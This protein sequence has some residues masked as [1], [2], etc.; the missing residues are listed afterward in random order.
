MLR[1]SRGLLFVICLAWLC[2]GCGD[3]D[4]VGGETAADVVSDTGGTTGGPGEDDT[5]GD[6]G[7]DGEGPTGE[8][9]G[10]PGGETGGP[11]GP[12]ALEGE[13]EEPDT[14]CL[15][16]CGG[17]ECG[18]DGCGGSCGD[19]AVGA[20]CGTDGACEPTPGTCEAPLGVL[21]GT[22]EG[23]TVDAIDSA[24]CTWGETTYGEGTVDT[25]LRFTPTAGGTH[26]AR[27]AGPAGAVLHLLTGCE[28]DASCTA[29]PA[30]EVQFEATQGQAVLLAVDGGEAGPF[31][32]TV[33]S[34][35][36][37]CP[38]G[39]CG[40]S[41]CGAVCLCGP[42]QICAAAPGGGGT[43]VPSDIGD[44]CE[45]ALAGGTSFS[46]E[47][48]SPGFTD[49]YSC[50]QTGPSQDVTY[51]LNPTIPV[52]VLINI[53]GDGAPRA[54]VTA[55]C[56][57]EASCDDAATPGQPLG[58]FA[59]PSANNRIVVEFG[60]GSSY[61]LTVTECPVGSCAGA[62]PCALGQICE[63]EQCVNPGT[64]DSCAEA[65]ALVPGTIAHTTGG[66]SDSQSCAEHPGLSEAVFTLTAP[67]AGTWQ[68]LVTS[69]APAALYTLGV[70][71]QPETCGDYALVPAE[72]E[73][74]LEAGEVLTV[75]VEA[76]T[77][78]PGV[79][80]EIGVTNC[81]A[82]CSNAPCDTLVCGD[83][84]GCPD[85]QVCVTGDGATATCEVAG[86]LDA[87]ETAET[88]D[89]APWQGTVALA[90]QVDSVGCGQGA[91]LGTADAWFRF[92]PPTTG[93]FAL[94]ISGPGSPVV[95]LP[96]TCDA[97]GQACFAPPSDVQLVVGHVAEER[98]VAVDAMVEA[99][100]DVQLTVARVFGLAGG[101]GAPC[102]F[103]TDCPLADACIA[104]ICALQCSPDGSDAACEG[105]MTG[106]RG[107]SFGCAADACV[108]AGPGCQTF[109]V[110]GATDGA[111]VTCTS[112]ADCSATS[113]CA[114]FVG[115]PDGALVGLCAKSGS[116]SPAGQP[117]QSA[118]DCASNVCVAG[119]CANL[120]HAAADCQST[121]WCVL[122]A[123]AAGAA[124][125]CHPAPAGATLEPCQTNSDCGSGGLCDGFASPDGELTLRCIE[126]PAGKQP[127]GDPC[128]EDS[129]CA[130][131]RCLFS[132]F[133]ALQLPYCS[134][135]C[136][137][138]SDCTG[139]LTCK[140][141]T[142]WDM[143]TPDTADDVTLPLC[144]AGGQDANCWLDGAEI[145]DEPLGCTDFLSDGT[146]GLCK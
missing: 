139:S 77:G 142:I 100:D 65:I 53:E 9:D 118:K 72:I 96:K 92:V 71:G 10:D 27:V 66:L 43:C 82:E 37:P 86:P 93:V 95:L 138:G 89:A 57:D 15:P 32:L 34:C 105:A 88:I 74:H 73:R 20:Q 44:F 38:T 76:P 62:C 59:Y 106:P 132:G 13:V 80:F 133:M 67:Q 79:G 117:C 140:P 64:G 25:V 136:A 5:G 52:G 1:P 123:T 29:E 94:S 70:C 112:N 143:G 31:E 113:T 99:A 58:V 91:G 18:G 101:L 4:E 84:C 55:T 48:S 54:Y 98:F 26:E 49:V 2:P 111:S 83:Q 42:K 40:A 69:P 50:G 126:V 103:A 8:P 130:A 45:T 90:E 131:A 119:A 75:A 97:G 36:D 81:S 129:D 87:C 137:S 78:G 114:G 102:D 41:K 63:A 23:T 116:L 19:C 6:P 122:T 115:G 146:F 35:A 104:G 134:E 24:R 110:A 121:D 144:V 68:V 51:Q 46:D 3:D 141:V 145:C 28:A 30:T 128:S 47:K 7:G 109:C 127:T 14:G 60:G 33:E 17:R 120:C 22:H 135:V 56:G 108:E 11:D 39:L 16:D 61:S 107:G 85:G 124:G 12:D 21:A 125:I